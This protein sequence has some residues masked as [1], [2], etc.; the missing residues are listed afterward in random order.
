MEPLSILLKWK[1]LQVKKCE[2]QKIVLSIII[3][4]ENGV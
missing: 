4:L 3:F 2:S 1:E